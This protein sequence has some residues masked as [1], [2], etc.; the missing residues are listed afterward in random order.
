M[1]QQEPQRFF[2][3]LVYYVISLIATLNVLCANK[4]YKQATEI[5]QNVSDE[6]LVLTDLMQCGVKC[7]E[8]CVR[9]TLLRSL[10]HRFCFPVIYNA[11]CPVTQ[12]VHVGMGKPW[13]PVRPFAAMLALCVDVAG[14]LDAMYIPPKKR[15]EV[16]MG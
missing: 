10:L 6:F 16:T 12:P 3:H 1:E 5:A 9:T 15:G 2:R 4:Q 13:K 8:E 7:V 14:G 11:V